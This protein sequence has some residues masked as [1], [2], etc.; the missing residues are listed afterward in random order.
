MVVNDNRLGSR[1]LNEQKNPAA[2][3]EGMRGMGTGQPGLLKIVV[4]VQSYFITLIPVVLL[5]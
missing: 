3:L 4:M 5:D 1:S 2:N